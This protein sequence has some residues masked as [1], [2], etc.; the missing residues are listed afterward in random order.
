MTFFNIKKNKFLKKLQ[1]QF[2]SNIIM[3]WSNV[4]KCMLVLMLTLGMHF[5]WIGWKLFIITNPMLW[6]WVDLPLLKSQIYFN[7]YA[8]I[9]V[10]HLIVFCYFFEKE[11]WANTIL[12]HIVLAIFV[13]VLLVDGFLVGIYS[14]ATIFAFVSISGL[15]LILFDRKIVYIQFIIAITVYCALMYCTYHKII[16]YAP[17]FSENLLDHR[18]RHNL[19][20]IVSMLYFIIPILISCFILCEILLTQWRHRESLIK[21]LSQTDPLTNLYNRRFFNE[22]LNFIQKN[23]S[24]YAIILMDIDH[25][26]SIND[27]YGH[28][29]GDEVLQRVA[30]LLSSQTRNTDIVARYGGEEFII[31][32]PDTSLG[33]AQDIAERCRLIIQNEVL[34]TL[35][36]KNIQLTASFG[37]AISIYETN[38][39]KVIHL[40]DQAL[41]HAKQL[42]RNQVQH[43]TD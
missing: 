28:H 9:L 37:V 35:E 5:L 26:K 17:L 23:Q 42:G 15:G 24:H 8:A 39:S 32:L 33:V 38:T 11:V 31:A 12:P 3:N 27:Q 7:I 25:F 21:R 40:A 29:I 10:S 43:Y 13:N 19:F 41:Y 34:E 22:R 18:P 36:H 20:W 6:Q 30:H 14:P 4:H 1:N 16:P 2:N